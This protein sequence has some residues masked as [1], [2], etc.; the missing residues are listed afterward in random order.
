MSHR[1]IILGDLPE[2][3]KVIR[4]ERE[5]IE[6]YDIDNAYPN[7]MERLINGSVTAKSSARMLSRFLIGKGF[8]DPDLNKVVIG[9]DRY[10]RPISAFKLLRQ[11]A[12]STAYYSGYYVRAQFDGNMNVTGLLHEDFKNC[13]FGLKN[14]QDYS[15]HIVVYNNWD[16]SKSQK[17][18]KKDYICVPVWNMNEAVIKYQIEKAKGIKNYKG[19]MFFNFLDELYIY[20]I[21]PIDPVHYDADTEHEISMFKN[22]ELRRGFFMKN[23]IHHNQFESQKDADDF[24]DA[25]LNFQGGG[26]KYSFMV[27]EGTF[28][29]DGNL[30]EGENIKVEKIEQNVNDKIFETYEKSC[31]NNI[32]KAY[33]AIPQMLIDHEDGKLGT[34]SGEALFQAS[35]FYNQMTG[36]LRVSISESFK[37]MFTRW[38]KP[39]L[40][41][42]E[43]VIEPTVLGTKSKEGPMMLEL[44][45]KTDNG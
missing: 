42:K 43:W 21:S 37:E 10:K 38:V 2:P 3:F 9:H 20:P 8:Q 1:R 25:I 26:H 15:D 28:D 23:I 44:T 22:G 5:G 32:R 11:I 36:E 12:V 30:K 13:R 31:I 4:R 40:R 27:L 16:N 19:Q 41:E 33:N 45:K 24:K 14:S 39:D 34:T 29:D 6:K 7:R 35:E 18:N 17:I